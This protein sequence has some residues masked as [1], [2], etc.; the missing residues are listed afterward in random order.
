MNGQILIDNIRS[1][2]IENLRFKS[3]DEIN[4][5]GGKA[6]DDLSLKDKIKIAES[7]KHCL[8]CKKLTSAKFTYFKFLKTDKN[9]NYIYIISVC[10]VC[11]KH[12]SYKISAKYIISIKNSGDKIVEV[13]KPKSTKKMKKI[14]ENNNDE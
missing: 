11:K 7:S 9:K 14:D 10:D 12:K 4:I 6:D 13:S 2:D 5:V 1:I 3:E 8:T